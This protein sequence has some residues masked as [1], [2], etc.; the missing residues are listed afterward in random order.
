MSEE[1]A[2]VQSP[3]LPVPGMGRQQ[4]PHQTRALGSLGAPSPYL[5]GRADPRGLDAEEER[6][7]RFRKPSVCKLFLSIKLPP[8]LVFVSVGSSEEWKEG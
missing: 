2:F 4:T 1:P 7:G 3:W 6:S 8:S 5:A